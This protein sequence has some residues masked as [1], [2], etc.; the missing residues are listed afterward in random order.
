MTEEFVS[1]QII[2]DSDDELELE[3]EII[4]EVPKKVRKPRTKSELKET[5]VKEEPIISAAPICLLKKSITV[6]ISIILKKDRLRGF[7]LQID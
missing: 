1:V 2:D 5:K 4:I 3:K 7:R 6:R